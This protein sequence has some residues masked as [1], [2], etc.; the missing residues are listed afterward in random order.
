MKQLF[1][2]QTSSIRNWEFT[3]DIASLIGALTSVAVIW[4]IA[5]G[6]LAEALGNKYVAGLF[7]AATVAGVLFIVDY[8]LRADLGYGFDLLFSGSVWK[9]WRLSAFLVLLLGFNVIRSAVTITLSWQGRKDVVTAVTEAPE[10]ADVGQAKTQMDNASA[11]RLAGIQ[12]QVANLQR[13]IREAEATAGS[14]ALHKLAATGNGWAKSELSKARAKASRSL[15]EQL[16]IAQAAYTR[17][18]T[19]DATASANAVSALAMGNAAKLGRY[20]EVSSRNMAYLGYFGAG[21]TFVVIMIS[22][23]LSLLNTAEQDAPIYSYKHN[24]N[25]GVYPPNVVPVSHT[26]TPT[27]TPRD[28]PGATPG[29]TPG[30]TPGDSVPRD[31]AS[32]GDTFEWVKKPRNVATGQ[33]KTTGDRDALRRKIAQY[34]RRAVAGT[35]SEKGQ[36]SLKKWQSQYDKMK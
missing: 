19:T 36:A 7:A 16:S 3:R 25:G 34:K 21:C 30:N 11:E 13:Q 31:V 14:A 29:A 4:A 10:L 22:L 6:N 5:Y 27:A 2:S 1:K 17:I 32:V 18:A 9:N 26:A 28:T 12:T 8:G 35:L 23:M 20:Q 33:R 24:V 15:R